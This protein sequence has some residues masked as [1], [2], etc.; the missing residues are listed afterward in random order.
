MNRKAD[1]FAKRI[2]SLNELNRISNW[3]ALVSPAVI[4]Q[5]YS[6]NR[7]LTR[8]R[9]IRVFGYWVAFPKYSLL[10]MDARDVLN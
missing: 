1:F 9:V 8:L 10:Q 2:D 7:A 3:N 6:D 5:I 4:P